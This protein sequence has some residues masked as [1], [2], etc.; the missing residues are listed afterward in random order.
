MEERTTAAVLDVGCFSAHLVVVGR[1]PE[2]L[3]RPLVSHKVRLRLDQ[4]LDPAGRI[5]AAGIDCVVEAVRGVQERLGDVRVSR[6]VPYATSCVRDAANAE[7][8]VSAVAR[9][10][11]VELRLLS[12][13]QEARYSYLAA[14]RWL[15]S[16]GPLG[17]LDIGGGTIELA[18]GDQVRPA[19]AGS[20]PL[21]ARTLTR[22]GLDS[23]ERVPGMRADLLR[24]IT[25]AVPDEVLAA[26]ADGPA[27]GCSKVFQQLAK[28]ANARG[29]DPSRLRLTDVQ[30][31]IPR[32]AALPPHR[33]ARLPGISR[34]RARQS[35]AGAVVAE[36][37]MTATN[38]D[39][40]RICPWSSKEGL[41]LTLLESAR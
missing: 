17:V 2:T 20:L 6:F 38:R 40:V 30:A 23:L 28:L 13:R 22:A 9:R 29:S 3:R 26:F 35:L 5:D 12:G 1:D 14:R 31:C 41:L 18:Q 34:H 33:R 8:V 10:T 36:A 25:E 27:I 4:A 16:A 15:G 11:G 7:E 24:G 39:V 19:F 37:V 32:L 21:G